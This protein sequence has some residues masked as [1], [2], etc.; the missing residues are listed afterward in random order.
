MKSKDGPSR[1]GEWFAGV[2]IKKAA[3][4]EIA[5]MIHDPERLVKRVHQAV[6]NDIMPQQGSEENDILVSRFSGDV[7]L[8]CVQTVCDEDD[9]LILPDVLEGQKPQVQG[10]GHQDQAGKILFPGLSCQRPPQTDFVQPT[11][12]SANARMGAHFRSGPP[13]CL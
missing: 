7:R 5:V 10:A 11:E 2:F 13:E 9:I 8:L 6:D 12:G 3:V 1:R 4:Q